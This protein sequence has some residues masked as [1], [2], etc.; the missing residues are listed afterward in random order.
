MW[1]DPNKFLNTEYVEGTTN[2]TQYDNNFLAIHGLNQ[3]YEKTA[4]SGPNKGNH[5]PGLE[6]P[7]VWDPKKKKE[8]PLPDPSREIAYDHAVMER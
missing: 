6:R 2:V 3:F 1:D 4:K 7:M 8:V 5:R